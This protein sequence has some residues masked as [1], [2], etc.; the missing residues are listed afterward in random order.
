MPIDINLLR[1]ERG[2]DPEKIRESERRR[3]NAEAGLVDKV[4]SL[5]RE[6][7]KLVGDVDSKK[8]E[9]ND[10]N[11]QVG[12][13]K[14]AKEDAS[15]LMAKSKA[16]SGE[17]VEMEKRLA[18]A[19]E[20]LDKYLPQIGNI[21]HDSVPVSND[22]HADNEIVNKWGEFR[23]APESGDFEYQSHAQL[24]WRIGGYEP[25]RGV[26]TAGHRAYYLTGPG[27]MLNQSLISYALGYLNKRGYTAI[28]PPYFMNKNV[29]AGVAQLS[30]FDEELYKVTGDGEEKYLIA[31]SEQPICAFHQGDWI[32]P[33]KLPIKYAGMSTCFR[34]EAGK[35]GKDTWG[36]FRVHQFDK[37]E[38]FCITSPDDDESW[39]MHEEMRQIAEDYL[40][41][42]GLPYQVVNIVSGE[43]NNAAAKK[44]DIEAWFP[45]Y[46][47][48]KELVSCSNCLDYQS[49]AVETRFGNKQKG[50]EKKYVH[51]LNST[52]CALT[53]TICCILENYQTK[54]GVVVPEALRPLMGTDF[55][56]F[57][58]KAKEN[59]QEKKMMKSAARKKRQAM[60]KAKKSSKKAP[61]APSAQDVAK[62]KALVEA[63]AGDLAAATAAQGEAVRKLKSEKA[64]KAA[65]G[66]AVGLLIAL[67]SLKL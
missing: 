17:I 53:R 23:T 49:R 29:M 58:R 39:K 13:L 22:E 16:L 60:E 11:K 18:A 26:S 65:V 9:K 7:C 25:E 38:Q 20:E 44:Y 35:H 14:K 50:K 66:A 46:K 48:C 62:A 10:L 5:D 43:L 42:L 2:G 37:I 41:S 34:K 12:K 64:D 4:I 21:V 55:L 36:I 45:A 24:L 33:K 61:A 47:E 54:D 1:V 51:M 32:S 6:W 56:P 40:Q 67:K 8:K 57:V 28:Q 27:V 30:Q 31:T 59:V 19:R 15:E 63:A 52:L 3:F